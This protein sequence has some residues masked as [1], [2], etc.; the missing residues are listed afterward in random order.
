MNSR[1][2][3]MANSIFKISLAVT[4]F[5]SRLVFFIGEMWSGRSFFWLDFGFLYLV[6]LNLGPW[7]GMFRRSD[8][9]SLSWNLQI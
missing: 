9:L 6:G 1:L 8:I 7:Y 3:R 2:Y 4:L 5:I